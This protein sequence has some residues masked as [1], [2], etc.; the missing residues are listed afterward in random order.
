VEQK[1]HVVKKAN[2]WKS[3]TLMELWDRTGEAKIDVMR[4]FFNEIL[5]NA[6]CVEPTS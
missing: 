2:V 4:K 6:I 1:N 3:L 5:I